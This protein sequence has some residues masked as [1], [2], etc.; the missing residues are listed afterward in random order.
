MALIAAHVEEQSKHGVR[1]SSQPA[2]PPT[3]C[4]SFAPDQFK[5]NS[6]NFTEI[7][8]LAGPI[9]Q[10]TYPHQNQDAMPHAIPSM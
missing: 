9:L 3:P 2:S 6:T 7:V 4:P 1:V 8:T 10:S 5:P